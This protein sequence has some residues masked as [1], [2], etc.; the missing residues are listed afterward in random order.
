MPDIEI[1]SR[2]LYFIGYLNETVQARNEYKCIYIQYFYGQECSVGRWALAW[3]PYRV[4]ES[5]RLA[6]YLSLVK[7]RQLTDKKRQAWKLRDKNCLRVV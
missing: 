3:L 4:I 6:F 5:G 2:K 1:L 7:T